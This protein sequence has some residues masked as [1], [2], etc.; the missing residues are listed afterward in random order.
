MKRI[1]QLLLHLYPA[2]YRATFGAEMLAVLARRAEERRPK[3]PAAV[4]R[5]SLFEMAGLIRQAAIQWWTKKAQPAMAYSSVRAP[6]LPPD[7]AE[8]E[9]DLKAMIDALV[10]AIATHQFEK[11]RF[12]SQEERKARVRLCLLRRQ[13]GIEEA[14]G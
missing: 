12:Y 5:F 6:D 11:A 8:A 14:P 1:W 7:V 10:N 3:G 13:H 9:N 2:D 4:V